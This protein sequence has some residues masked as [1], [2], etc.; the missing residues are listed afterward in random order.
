MA[1]TVYFSD[2][3]CE[4]LLCGDDERKR[5]LALAK[6]IRERLGYDSEALLNS[7][8]ESKNDQKE[9]LE[10][11]LESYEASCGNYH[12]VLNDALEIAERVACLLGS[13]RLDR[14]ELTAT[15]RTLICTINKEL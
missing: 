9:L 8:L 7:I 15:V 1:E 12:A 13:V 2:G 6:I 3:S 10:D 4:V 5:E 11:E 14:K